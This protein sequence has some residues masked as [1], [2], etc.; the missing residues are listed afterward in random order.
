[1][2]ETKL[3]EHLSIAVE[4]SGN[5]NSAGIRGFVMVVMHWAGFSMSSYMQIVRHPR[6]QRKGRPICMQSFRPLLI[7]WHFLLIFNFFFQNL[8]ITN[9][10]LEGK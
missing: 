7:R 6:I 2:I 5:T 4:N 10:V 8:G 1:M 3:G 9:N